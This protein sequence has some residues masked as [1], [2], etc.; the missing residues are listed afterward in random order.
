MNHFKI[1]PARAA[2]VLF[3][4]SVVLFSTS[5]APFA[6][7]RD[8]ERWDS[9]YENEVYIFG[10]EPVR[11]LRENLALLPKGKVLDIAMGE[12]RNGVYLAANGF[13]V[14]GIDI[15]EVGLNKAHKLAEQNGTKITTR[16]VDLENTQL[17]ESTYDV[18][19]CTYYMQ[20]D[21]V[22]QM[23]KAVKPGGVV[24]F[25]TY[26]AD[27][28]KYRQ[29]NPKWVLKD[30][31]LLEMFRDFKILRY[32]AYDDGTEAYSSIIAQRN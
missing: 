6:S 31:E 13:E 8:K 28:L 29:F 15:S 27:Y 2:V 22:P 1:K 11:F 21:L 25:E 23:K 17:P 20:R 26:N 30:N 19:L 14:E 3:L 9:K 4:A 5:G 12:G 16:V 7:P 32:Q 18:V 10:T 24:V